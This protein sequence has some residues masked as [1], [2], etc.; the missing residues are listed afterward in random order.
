MTD[1]AG[2]L[3]VTL[4]NWALRLYG[5]KTGIDDTYVYTDEYKTALAGNASRGVLDDAVNGSAGGRNTINAAAVSGDT[6][7]DLL[8]GQ[9]SLGGAALTISNPGSIQNIVT[10]DGND[11]LVAGDAAA[12]LDGG[13]GQNTLTGG[14]GKDVFVVRRR[15]GGRD[16][17]SN[18]DAAHGDLID[19]VGFAGKKFG[20][21]VLTQQGEDVSV[22][23]GAGQSIVIRNQT[24]A[25]IAAEQFF[26]FQDTFTAPAA[27]VDSNSSSTTVP[28]GDGVITLAGGGGGVSITSSPDGQMLWS[29][30]GTIYSHDSATSDRFVIARQPG[31]ANYGNA[32][33]GFKHGVDKIDLSALGITSFS[34]LTIAQQDRGVVNGVATIHG[35]GISSS[36]LGVNGTAANLLYLDGLDPAQV[37][38]S[39]FIF[40]PVEPTAVG[41]I[42]DP[43]VVD[44]GVDATPVVIPPTPVG[45][46]PVT[47]P[48]VDFPI[49]PSKPIELRP[50][51]RPHL[52]A[53]AVGERPGQNTHITDPT[54]LVPIVGVTPVVRPPV[55]IPGLRPVVIPPM[56][57]PPW[58]RDASARMADAVGDHAPG[59]TLKFAHNGQ[60]QV[61]P[62]SALSSWALS[63]ALLDFHLRGSEAAAIGGELVDRNLSGSSVT[64]AQALL[65]SPRFGSGS[66]NLQTL[67]DNAFRL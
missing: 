7:I 60:D 59:P 44:P 67:Q 61:A 45:I 11:T 57:R 36:A 25:A 43:S 8:S 54:L 66:H 29:L 49:L 53:P 30:T 63:S 23:L 33:R 1:A 3:P 12:I 21:L 64:A 19:L 6:T 31:K 24:V 42:P 38:E 35:V 28:G 34:E 55:T 37:A 20:D 58:E 62:A 41:V 18:F 40:A 22:E 50:S 13:R 32:L 16:T 10:G 47:V 56:P 46:P 26:T 17:L 48:P 9:A 52:V 51:G 65:A 15:A 39:D 2:G 14:N 27:Y 4:N 5:S